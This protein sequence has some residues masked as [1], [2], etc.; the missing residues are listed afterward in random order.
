M[1]ISRD[2]YLKQL[3]DSSSNGLIKIITGLRRSGKSFLLFTLFRDHLIS[4]GIAPSHI[5]GIAFDDIRVSELRDPMKLI[6]FIDSKITD[7]GMYYILLDEVQMLDRFVEVLNSLLHIKNADVYVTGSNS[8]FLSSDI[9]TEFRGRGDI[10]HLRPLSFAEI[11]SAI[12][13]DKQGLWKQYYTYGG[14]PQVQQFNDDAKKE[15]YLVSLQET[16]YLRDI[17]ERNQVRNKPEFKEL[18]RVIA[19]TVGSPCNPTR[20]SNTFKSKESITI[21]PK[22]IASYLGFME[23]SFLIDRAE[24]YDVKG[25]KYIGSLSK[26]YFEDIGLRNALLGFRQGEEN[27]IMENVI[28]NELRHRG[29]LVD[30]GVV[31]SRTT[32]SRN[33]LEVDF[34]ANRS[35]KRYYIQSAYSMA[36]ATK[37]EQETASLKAI[38]DAFT[39]VII[40]RDDIKPYRDKNGFLII[41]LFDFLLNNNILSA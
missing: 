13:G 41:G 23:D 38:D 11:H 7:S 10:I 20:I 22:T 21:D 5:I 4:S 14:L 35:N 37:Q 2:T 32:G 16:V 31:E 6:A 34:V 19:S 18:M 15:D 27:H 26:Y 30:V 25:R 28:Y 39:R 36:D 24:R 3:I 1:I 8:R 12:G 40:V 33:K 9:A 17:F 29:F